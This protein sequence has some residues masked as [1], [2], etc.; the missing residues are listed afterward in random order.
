MSADALRAFGK[1]VQICRRLQGHPGGVNPRKLRILGATKPKG[2]WSADGVPAVMS[3]DNTATVRL[4]KLNLCLSQI[5]SEHIGDAGCVCRKLDS[6][7]LM[8]K[9]AKDRS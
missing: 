9:A 3:I 7:I 4:A 2:W 5:K 1:R 8:V 6:A